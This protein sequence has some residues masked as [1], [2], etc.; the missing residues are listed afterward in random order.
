MSLE[1]D[2]AT[3]AYRYG[4]RSVPGITRL[5]GDLGYNKGARF[6]TEESR[7]RGQAVHKVLFHIEELCPKVTELDEVLECFTSLDERLHPFIDQYLHFKREN[8]FEAEATEQA[9]FSKKLNAA[10]RWD[11]IGVMKRLNKRAL[12][13]TKTWKSQGPKPKRGSELQTAFYKM[14]AEEHLGIK[15][16]TRIVLKLSGMGFYRAYTCADPTDEYTVQAAA[17]VWWDMHNHNL[18]EVEDCNPEED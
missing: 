2:A 4:G 7:Q 16:D 9:V 17:R 11:I 10:G 18:F 1:Y 15:V 12:V 6:Y 5:L 13:D 14:G 3:H 8:E